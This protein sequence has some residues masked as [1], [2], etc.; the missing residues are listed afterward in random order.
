MHSTS[1]ASRVDKEARIERLKL[2]ILIPSLFAG[3]RLTRDGRL[4]TDLGS[5]AILG[6]SGLLHAFNICIPA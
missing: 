2:S 1:V 5:E 6:G 4:P 3:S